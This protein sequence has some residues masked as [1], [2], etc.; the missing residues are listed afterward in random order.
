MASGYHGKPHL[1]YPAE[2]AMVLVAA[3]AGSTGAIAR[4]HQ[5]FPT[6][7]VKTIRRQ[8]FDIRQTAD[9]FKLVPQGCFEPR[10]H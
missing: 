7:T 8:N 1:Q 10:G 3:P 4:F 6:Y 9:S 5:Y 2:S